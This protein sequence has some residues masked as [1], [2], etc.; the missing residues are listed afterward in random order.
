MTIPDN[1]TIETLEISTPRGIE[2]LTVTKN[3][4]FYTEEPI[5]KWSDATNIINFYELSMD[6]GEAVEL[7]RNF[8]GRLWTVVIDG[9][10]KQ[11]QTLDID[12]LIKMFP[13]EERIYR[14]RCVEGWSKVIPWVGFP[15]AEF[16]KSCEPLASAKYVEFY[17]LDDPKTLPGQL[18]P[19]LDWPYLEG[20]R[21][22]EAMHPLSL[23]CFGMYGRLLPGQNGAPV[24]LVIP[25]KYAFKSIKSIVRLRFVEEMP[26]TSWMKASPREYGFYA[27]VNPRVDHPRWSQAKEKRV[28]EQGERE[29]LMFNGYDEVADLYRGMDLRKFF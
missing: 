18:R 26:I 23:L 25:W 1:N 3:R 14:H 27:N 10:V 16:I 9:L 22:D 6:K 11:K 13:L 15:L 29:T 7:G 24:R 12:Q 28:G 19:V 5:T 2:K 21:M 4:R 8:P 20:L 17:S